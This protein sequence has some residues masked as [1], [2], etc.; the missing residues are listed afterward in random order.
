MEKL[1]NLLH[2]S[3][4]LFSVLFFGGGGEMVDIVFR[5]KKNCHIAA[6]NR[7]ESKNSKKKKR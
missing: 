6:K 5:I 1:D 2:E 7:T 4:L 3:V